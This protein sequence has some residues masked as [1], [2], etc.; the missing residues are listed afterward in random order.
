MRQKIRAAGPEIDLDFELWRL[1]DHTRFMIGRLR[2]ME[3][4][5]FGLTPEQSHVLYILVKRGGA[6]TIND[7]VEITQRQH[8]SISTL[9][10]RMTRQGLVT[11][12]KT[13]TDNRKYDVVIT[14]RGQALL[15]KLGRES[16]QKTFSCLTGEKREE[17]I[18]S[19]ICLRDKAYSLHGKTVKENKAV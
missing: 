17:F 8:H 14:G 1:F 4:A 15:K 10:N 13:T 11:K 18:A 6:T 7:I 3:L 9:I 2:E 5:E 19:L 12:K 16:I